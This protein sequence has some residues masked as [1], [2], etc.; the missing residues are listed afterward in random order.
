MRTAARFV[1]IA[2]VAMFGPLASAQNVQ[3]LSLQ[4]AEQIAIQNHPQI[5]AAA[6]LA[7]AAEAQ[8]REV[9]AP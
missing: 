2:V 9:R 7:A 6:A 5:Q 8:R 3:T 1:L 4:Q